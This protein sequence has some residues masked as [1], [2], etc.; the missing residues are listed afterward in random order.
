MGSKAVKIYFRTCPPNHRIVEIGR[1][2]WRSNFDVNGNSHILVEGGSEIGAV[3]S[4]Q[5]DNQTAGKFSIAL[6]MI[7]GRRHRW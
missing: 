6:A 5:R 4:S 7:G 2:L 1:D 3:G